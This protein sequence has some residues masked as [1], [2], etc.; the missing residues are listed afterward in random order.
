MSLCHCATVSLCPCAPVSLFPCFPVSLLPCF[1]TSLLPCFPVSLL[2]QHLLFSFFFGHVVQRVFQGVPNFFSFFPFTV[3]FSIFLSFVLDR[4]SFLAGFQNDGVDFLFL[5][6]SVPD[7]VLHPTSKR[8]TFFQNLHQ[9]RQYAHFGVHVQLIKFKTSVQMHQGF[10]NRI[11][12]TNNQQPQ[13]TKKQPRSVTI[14]HPPSLGCTTFSLAYLSQ[15]SAN[16]RP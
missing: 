5:H 1:P 8:A 11:C 9:S 3:S 10:L 2:S 12:T 6:H 15:F 16:H 13:P 4:R 7:I 14:N